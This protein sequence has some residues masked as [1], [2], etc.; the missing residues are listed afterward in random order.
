[1][2]TFVDI[3]LAGFVWDDFDSVFNNAFIAI[4]GVEQIADMY[5][6]G[7]ELSRLNKTA[8]V[9]PFRVSEELFFM[10]Y[11]ADQLNRESEGVFDITIAPIAALWKLCIQNKMLPD[12][13]DIKDNLVLTG[14]GNIALDPNSR[15][16]FFKKNGMR[17]DLGAVAKGYAVDRA[18]GEI[19][20]SGIRSAMINAGGDIFCIGKKGPLSP[21]RIG[22]RDPYDKKN[23]CA[24][25]SL[26]DKAA[27]TSGGYE[28]FFVCE[29]RYYSHLIDPRNGYPV[30]G[31]YSSVTV[32]AGSCF[33]ADAF[34]T[35]IFVGGEQAKNKLLSLYPDIEVVTI[36]NNF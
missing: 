35:A 16:V 12:D 6:T 34:A 17:I 7:S 24:A 5:D 22:I 28:Q 36:K 27:A 8:H 1:M 10:I 3:T 25:I 31:E 20:R 14:G 33:F 11:N 29:G 32:I 15:E 13:R 18:A 30:I 9:G 2:G 23:V 26:S 19:R 4:D 21:W